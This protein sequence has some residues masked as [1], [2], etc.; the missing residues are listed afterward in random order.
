MRQKIQRVVAKIFSRKLAR[1][2][3]SWKYHC[4]FLA[5][6]DLAKQDRARRMKH[7]VRRTESRLL[8]TAYLKWA[9]DFRQKK[10]VQNF[11]QRWLKRN[12][13]GAFDGW[14][15]FV[16][17][18]QQARRL[19]RRVTQQLLRDKLITWLRFAKSQRSMREARSK[20]QMQSLWMLDC[21]AKS[22]L[23]STLKKGFQMLQDHRHQQLAGEREEAALFSDA[24]LE[25]SRLGFREEG[26]DSILL[27]M[28][29][30]VNRTF[31]VQGAKLHVFD[32]MQRYFVEK[33]DEERGQSEEGRMTTHRVFSDLD[34][35]DDVGACLLECTQD[36]SM[37]WFHPRERHKDD[38]DRYE[39][40]AEHTTLC[41]PVRSCPER[42]VMAVLQ[43]EEKIL[44]QPITKEHF[45]KTLLT[46]CDHISG[47]LEMA[48]RHETNQ[49]LAMR[50]YTARTQNRLLGRTFANWKRSHEKIVEGRK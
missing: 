4:K 10:R 5:Q 38:P 7:F 20:K 1:G 37:M 23:L 11:I 32:A 40:L 25:F 48:C 34:D 44:E 22:S 27:Q 2:F 6:G 24:L 36:L 21:L 41:I 33:I 35:E 26:L 42:D 12:Q 3:A 46:F 16:Q 43:L 49:I 19:L 45:Q 29:G 50:R 15:E 17:K 8:A 28:E 13:A 18:S 47:P 31:H 39:H 14:T 30:M 9:H